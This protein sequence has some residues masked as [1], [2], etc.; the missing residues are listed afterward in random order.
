[1][2]EQQ[3]QALSHMPREELVGFE[4]GCGLYFLILSPGCYSGWTEYHGRWGMAGEEWERPVAGPWNYPDGRGWWSALTWMQVTEMLSTCGYKGKAKGSAHRWALGS[5]RKWG[6]PLNVYTYTFLSV[7]LS[8]SKIWNNWSGQVGFWSE[9]LG[10]QN[11]SL[12]ESKAYEKGRSE[13][14]EIS[15]MILERLGFR[16]R[17]DTQRS[18]E[19][20]S[21]YTR[22]T[23]RRMGWPA[24]TNLRDISVWIAFKDMNLEITE[25]ANIDRKE[26]ESRALAHCLRVKEMRD[27]KWSVRKRRKNLETKERKY[28]DR[29]CSVVSKAADS[30][31][32]WVLE[33]WLLTLVMGWDLVT[34]AKAGKWSRQAV[35]AVASINWHDCSG[36]QCSNM[37]KIHKYSYFWPYNFS[38]RNLSKETIRDPIKGLC[39]C[40]FISVLFITIK[41]WKQP[42]YMID[43]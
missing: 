42:K 19:T 17:V 14:L 2:W 35:S 13:A 7:L 16:C 28:Q 26:L 15:N 9:Q 6:I 10:K 12:W 20:D 30:S 33:K 43:N 32:R 1:M 4:Q 11:R 18:W 29:E 37:N 39:T 24:D 25:T 21:E 5:K 40:V 27:Q 3:W 34:M 23:F 41:H 31:A 36:K 22:L 8:W 38:S